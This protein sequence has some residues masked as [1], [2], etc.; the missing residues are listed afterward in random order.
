[1]ARQDPHFAGRAKADLAQLEEV[2]GLLP[3]VLLPVEALDLDVRSFHAVRNRARVAY[4]GQLVQA[5]EAELL[6]IPNF[7]RRSLQRVEGALGRRGLTIGMVL[8]ASTEGLETTGVDESLMNER[9]I[10]AGRGASARVWGYAKPGRVVDPSPVYEELCLAGIF[11]HSD[12]KDLLQFSSSTSDFLWFRHG[13][14]TMCELVGAFRDGVLVA[15]GLEP[16]QLDEVA[17]EL[18]KVG[19]GED[20]AGSGP[21]EP[22]PEDIRILCDLAMRRLPARERAYVE[23]HYIEGRPITHLAREEGRSCERGRQVMAK[24]IRRGSWYL[25]E[26]FRKRVARLV[27]ALPGDGTP[28]EP[29]RV[30]ELC[31][32][33]E[34]GFVRL[35]LV[36]SGLAKAEVR[37]GGLALRRPR[38]RSEK[39]EHRNLR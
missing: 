3:W 35:A 33:G 15:R 8:P 2:S 14:F 34:L 32:E 6:K 1:M 7:G 37:R 38:P 26:L 19:V 10:R 36:Y 17:G 16:G 18:A 24:G 31:G 13:V 9:M 21:P 20:P 25:R 12:W 27:E 11:P 30:R 28:L 29:E 23:G 5:T 39:I 22:R 4:V